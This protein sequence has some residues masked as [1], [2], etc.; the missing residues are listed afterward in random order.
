MV[1][2]VAEGAADEALTI[3]ESMT[4]HFTQGPEELF[5]AARCLCHF[6]RTERAI[7]FL[8]RAVQ[9]G[10]SSYP[11]IARDPWLQDLLIRP[12]CRPV[13]ERAREQHMKAVQTFTAVEGDRILR[14]RSE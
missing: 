9:E 8:S 2:A 10:F 1:R 12:G 3:L 14:V 13:L 5:Y 7:E 6:G 4:A 11:A